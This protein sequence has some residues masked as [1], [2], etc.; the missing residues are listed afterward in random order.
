MTRPG[1]PRTFC[2]I[3]NVQRDQALRWKWRY[4]GAGGTM[5]EA[6]GDYA[7]FFECVE[8][9]RAQGFQPTSRWTGAMP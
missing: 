8:A 7:L 9:A 2:E 6:E 5:I 1:R 3:Y 4:V